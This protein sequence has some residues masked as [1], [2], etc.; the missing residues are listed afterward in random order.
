MISDEQGQIITR[1][2]DLNKGQ[3]IILALADGTAKA[4]VEEITKESEK[5]E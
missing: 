5:N 3:N 1:T 2:N 4:T